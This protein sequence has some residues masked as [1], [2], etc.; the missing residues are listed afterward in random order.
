M[1]R[2]AIN[3]EYLKNIVLKYI[4]CMNSGNYKEGYTLQNVIGTVL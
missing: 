4:E 3:L 1:S 2:E